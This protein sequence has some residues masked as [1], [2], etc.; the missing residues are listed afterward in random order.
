MPILTCPECHNVFEPMKPWQKYCGKICNQAAYLRR[1]VDKMRS[2]PLHALTPPT[3]GPSEVQ[4][5]EWKRR[6]EIAEETNTQATEQTEQLERLKA[7][8]EAQEA[9]KELERQEARAM[10]Q[11]KYGQ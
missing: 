10:M 4:E 6:T 7:I 8:E 11:R 1:K 5:A 2:D 3:I 9:V